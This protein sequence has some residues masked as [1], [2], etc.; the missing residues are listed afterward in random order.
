MVNIPADFAFQDSATLESLESGMRAVEGNIKIALAILAVTLGRIK[1]EQLFLS[2]AP[3]FKA[4]LQQERTDLSYRKAVHLA[5]IGV[6]FWEYRSEL[7][8][9]EIRLSSV[10]SKIRLI[11]SDIADHDPMIW[12]R[13]KSLSVREFRNYI[14]KRRGDI[15]VYTAGGNGGNLAG[16]V[17]VSGLSLTIGGKKVRG[18]NLNQIREETAK[19][20][21]AVVL[22]V[23]DDNEARRIKRRMVER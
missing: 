20:K 21:R 10:M 16:S 5:S 15:N 8:E 22:W 13:L 3:N 9:N 6:K 1:R 2:V 11:D 4:Y 14:D 12:E 17:T 23:D 18:I 19:G 7:Q